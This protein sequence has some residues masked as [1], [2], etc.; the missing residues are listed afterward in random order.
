MVYAV[1]GVV[2]ELAAD[3]KSVVIH[4]E[5]VTNYMPA[6]T[7]PFEVHDT[8]EVRGLQPGERIGFQMVV[9]GDAAWIEHI[10][11]L[12]AAQQVQQPSRMSFRL[13]RDVDLLAVGDALFN[14]ISPMNSARP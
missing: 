2:K 13:V 14:T 11:K 12:N 5:A 4:H 3:G 1:R 6:M 7:M 10:T 8:T 9:A